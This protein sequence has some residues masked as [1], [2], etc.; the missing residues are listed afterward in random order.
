MDSIKHSTMQIDNEEFGSIQPRGDLKSQDEKM[1]CD[2]VQNS[3]G[4]FVYNVNDLTRVLRFLCLGTEGGSYYAK[5]PELKREN[6]QCIDR[7]IMNGRG[8]EVVELIYTVSTQGRACKQGPTLYALAICSRCNDSKTKTAAY[9]ILGS[10]C[11]IPT[12]LFEFVKYC[13]KESSGTGWGRA[14]RVAIGK[15]YNDFSK[16]PKKLAYLVTKYQNRHSWSH[17]DVVRLAHIKPEDS[18]IDMILKYVVKDMASANSLYSEDKSVVDVKAFLD[19]VEEAKKC[20]KSD[21][22]KLRALIVE[23][24]LVREHVP[25]GL[26]D[27]KEVWD[28]LLRLMPMMAMIRNLG[29]MS[30]LGLLDSGSVGETLVVSKLGNEELLKSARIH[31]FSLLV[32]WNQYKAGRG[33]KGKLSWSVNDNITK[34]LEE[35]FYKAFKFVPPTGKRYLLAV[36]VS[37]SMQTPVIGSSEIEAFEASAAMM[38]LTARTEENFEVIAFSKG[39]TKLDIYRGDTLKTVLKKCSNLPFSGTDCSMPMLYAIDHKK[40][41]DVFIVYTDSE[42][43][44]GKMHPSEA[45]K[46]YREYAKIHDARLIVV[47]MVSNGFSIADPNDPFMMD[48]VGFDTEAPK[49]MSNFVTG[50]F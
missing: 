38:L 50:K 43:Y 14:H 42:T 40:K 28:T 37:G 47:G 15:W 25:T 26:L 31:P 33:S 27:S 13:E 41:F 44:H 19:A 9:K 6:I 18:K 22:D 7:L 48:V 12:H 1:T 2:Q 8:T 49:A 20:T 34:A 36:D 35:A 39:Y 21:I 17:R 24:Q 5:E 46:Q 16:D 11:R 29:K 45:L 4:G 3:T 23:H 10:V 32:A 30:T